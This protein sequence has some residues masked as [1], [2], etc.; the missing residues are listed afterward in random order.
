MDGERKS[1][2]KYRCRIGKKPYFYEV[3]DEES[4]DLDNYKDF[5]YL[6]YYTRKYLR[7]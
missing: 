5:E 1:L 7:K 6:K 4:V 3:S 2:K